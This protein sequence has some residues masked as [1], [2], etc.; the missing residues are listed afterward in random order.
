M[1]PVGVVIVLK[2]FQLLLQIAFVPEKNLVQ[3]FPPDGADEPFGE[4]MRQGCMGN[5]FDLLDL[6]DPQ[7]GPPLV[8][9]KQGIV[10]RTKITGRAFA[11]RSMIEHTAKGGTVDITGMNANVDDSPCELIH[12]NQ[13]PVGLEENGLAPEQIDTPK[14]IFHMADEGEPRGPIS[15]LWTIVLGKDTPHDIFV[16]IDAKGPCDLPAR[17]VDSRTGDCGAISPKSAG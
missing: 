4:G 10:I 7:I 6:A 13:D 8:K 1:H 3:E 9:S 12:D 2:L 11:E 5:G 14:A 16:D 15:W 17:F